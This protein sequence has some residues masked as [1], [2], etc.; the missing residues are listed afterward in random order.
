M[1]RVSSY[2]QVKDDIV[3][4][5][6]VIPTVV[7]DVVGKGVNA[8][9]PEEKAGVGMGVPPR[10]PTPASVRTSPVHPLA[11]I[12]RTINEITRAGIW[13]FTVS[14]HLVGSRGILIERFSCGFK[15]TNE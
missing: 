11:K 6:G 8:A 5:A 13:E 7:R 15:N 1:I 9:V 12:S 2:S 10:F 3:S 14:Q 4:P